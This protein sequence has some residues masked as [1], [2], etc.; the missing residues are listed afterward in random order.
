[1][2]CKF[3][4]QVV[5]P[6]KSIGGKCIRE[7]RSTHHAPRCSNT[8]AIVPGWKPWISNWVNYLNCTASA[9][10]KLNLWTL[11][12]LSCPGTTFTLWFRGWLLESDSQ[13]LG[14]HSRLQEWWIHMTTVL[15][16]ESSPGTHPGSQAQARTSSFVWWGRKSGWEA[17]Q[18][19]GRKNPWKYF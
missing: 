18:K 12:C 13:A 10:A 6:R 15:L 5:N 9:Q 1:M 8:L 17:Q 4:V 11:L 7:V 14:P 16:A 2:L 3:L 19:W